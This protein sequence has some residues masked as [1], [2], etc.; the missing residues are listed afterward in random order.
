MIVLIATIGALMTFFF[1]FFSVL[2]IR[3]N[4]SVNIF[5]RLRRHNIENK[6]LKQTEDALRRFYKFIQRL[7]KPLADKGIT[8]KLDFR[9]KQAGIPLFGGEFIVL[10]AIGALFGGLAVYAITLNVTIAPLAAMGIPLC[11]WIWS[12]I[13]IERRRKAFTEQLGDCLTTVANALRAGYSFQQAM[14]VVSREMEPPMS[15]EF[16]RV[17]TDIAMGVTLED[18]LQQMNHR[19]GSA[20][21]DLVVTAVLIQREIGGNLAQILDSISDTITERIRMK[22]EIKALTAQGRFSAWVLIMLPFAV[23]AFCYVFNHDQ[24]MMLFT[25]DSGRIALAGALVME[26]LGFIVIRK[27][28]DIEV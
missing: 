16:E 27:I 1:V 4:Q 10:S 22:R 17:S 6:K 15:T 2:F 14:D 8:K 21:F 18:A 19:I 13:R 23:A 11:L 20:D 12:S 24:M 25:E 26:F 7:A 5:H 9:L 3:R 28:V